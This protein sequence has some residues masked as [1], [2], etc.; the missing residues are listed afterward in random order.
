[1]VL[2]EKFLLVWV[3]FLLVRVSLVLFDK[4]SMVLRVLVRDLVFFGGICYLVCC[5][6]LIFGGVRIVFGVVFRLEIIMGIC[7]VWDF[8]VVCLKVLGVFVEVI[9]EIFVKVIVV[10]ILV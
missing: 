4:V 6:L 3:R 1:M 9:M 2:I 10:G 5:F 8:M 7:V